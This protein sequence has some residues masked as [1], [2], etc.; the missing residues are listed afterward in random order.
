M[1]L[2]KVTVLAIFVFG[3]GTASY[4]QDECRGGALIDNFWEND[5]EDCISADERQDNGFGNG[6]QVAPGNSTTNNNAENAG[7]TE[8]HNPDG[9]VNSPGNSGSNGNNGKK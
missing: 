1:N 7:A 9:T 4:A 2:S 8:D 6:D 5:V 3:L